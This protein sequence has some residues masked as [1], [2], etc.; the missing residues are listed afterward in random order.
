MI[1][2]ANA[3]SLHLRRFYRTWRHC[4]HKP[5]KCASRFSDALHTGPV[6]GGLEVRMARDFYP[7]QER[8]IL[9][10]TKRF[11]EQIEAQP[12]AYGLSFEQCAQYAL[13]Q[14]AFADAFWV[15]ND[16]TTA[17]RPAR[18]VKN[19]ARVALEDAT[20]FLARI[21]RAHPGVTT[22]MRISLGLSEADVGD[23]G[24]PL[25]APKEEPVVVV[26]SNAG[27]QIE[28]ELRDAV[29]KIRKPAGVA[30]ALLFVRRADEPSSNLSDWQFIEI[31]TR[32]RETLT[33]G[34][35]FPAGARVWI[36]AQWF[37]P[38]GARGPESAPISAYLQGALVG[39]TSVAQMAA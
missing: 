12:D 9:F 20:R 31:T 34:L 7:R 38:T 5:I 3:F 16:P 33:F 27:R 18:I 19:K 21:I 25:G 1:T 28:I 24:A 11:R 13:T 26:R 22:E 2:L 15:V 35:E 6:A 17:T 10:F 30:G 29:G 14:Q 37:S 36:M 4:R 23:G 8:Q 39:P 32:A